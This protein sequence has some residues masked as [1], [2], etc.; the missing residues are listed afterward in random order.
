MTAVAEETCFTLS[1]H[2]AVAEPET[3]QSRYIARSRTSSRQE[4]IGQSSRHRTSLPGLGNG[5]QR[6]LH[7]VYLPLHIMYEHQIYTQLS[8]QHR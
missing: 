7:H 4:R 1:A 6:A 5:D 2:T 3:A 8:T